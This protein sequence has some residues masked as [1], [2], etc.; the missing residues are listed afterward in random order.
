VEQQLQELDDEDLKKHYS[1]T[2]LYDNE[3][4]QYYENHLEWYFNPQLSVKPECDYYQRLVLHDH[5]GTS[6]FLL[7][8]AN[9]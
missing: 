1:S 3:Y 2:D 4:F 8:G 6:T 7:F 5:V 9:A